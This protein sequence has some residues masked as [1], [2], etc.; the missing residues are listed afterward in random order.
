MNLS[1]KRVDDADVVEV[2]GQ[3]DVSTIADLEEFIAELDDRDLVLDMTGVNFMDT[4]GVRFL[5]TLASRFT[6]EER[7]I[8]L[9][10]RENSP[11]LLLLKITGLSDQFIIAE[12]GETVPGESS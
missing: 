4:T 9:V 3:V 7:S 6:S 11:V 12:P 10:L 1:A 2:T 5:L 8:R